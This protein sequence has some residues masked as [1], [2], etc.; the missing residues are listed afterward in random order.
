[1]SKI[2]WRIEEN[3]LV[4]EDP[5]DVHTGQQQAQAQTQAANVA[6]QQSMGLTISNAGAAAAAEGGGGGGGDWMSSL[7]GLFC[8]LWRTS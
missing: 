1:M 4:A 7:A 5:S 6:L 8:R 2:D 3:D